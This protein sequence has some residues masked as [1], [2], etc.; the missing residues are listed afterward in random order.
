MA[1]AEPELMVAVESFVGS[2]DGNEI[3]IKRG[4]TVTSDHAIA[5]AFPKFF[6]AFNLGEQAIVN[7][8]LEIRRAQEALREKQAGELR[9]HRIAQ[10]TR[11]DA[12]DDAVAESAKR[13]VL[14]GNGELE[15]VHDSTGLVVGARSRAGFVM[16]S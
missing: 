13:A 7:R 1:K 10:G 16:T 2:L 9:D 4:F 14:A 6:V 11:A 12:S 15:L 3:A 8:L 5:N